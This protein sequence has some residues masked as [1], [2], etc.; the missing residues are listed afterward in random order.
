MILLRQD[1]ALLHSIAE[2]LGGT[3]RDMAVEEARLR[4]GMGLIRTED[5]LRR[6]DFAVSA[7]ENKT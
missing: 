4:C 5:E 7:E 6:F 1:P 3:H 2:F